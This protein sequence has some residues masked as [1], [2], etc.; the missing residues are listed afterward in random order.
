M[1]N[2]P[3]NEPSLSAGIN[4]TK[5][6][7]YW[8]QYLEQHVVNDA[9]LLFNDGVRRQYPEIF[10][11]KVERAVADKI[12]ALCKNNELSVYLYMLAA[13]GV[14][15]NKY[16]GAEYVTVGMPLVNEKDN[17]S[18]GTYNKWLPLFLSINSKRTFK[19]LLGVTS[20]IVSELVMHQ[21]YPLNIAYG[22]LNIQSAS[23]IFDTVFVCNNLHRVVPGTYENIPLV[24][25]LEIVE[26]EINFQLTTSVEPPFSVDVFFDHFHYV[27]TSAVNSLDKPLENIRISGNTRE[28][29]ALMKWSAGGDKLF[30]TSF[31]FRNE[32]S[33]CLT[34][35]GGDTAV[36]HGGGVLSYAALKHMADKLAG[37]LRIQQGIA[38]GQRVVV[39]Q[40]RS[41][42]TVVAALALLQYG[43]V[44]VPV[45]I[46]YPKERIRFMLKDIQPACVF[47]E[48]YLKDWVEEQGYK[49]F[50]LS[51]LLPSLDGNKAEKLPVVEIM[52]A[53]EAYIIYTSGSTGTPKGVRVS[54]ANLDH[55]FRHVYDHY[56][57]DE[58]LAMALLASH[59]FDISLFQLFTPLLSGGTCVVADKEE[60][61]DMDKLMSVLKNVTVIDTVPG[62]YRLLVQYI[63][64]RNL[65]SSFRHIRKLFI[66]GDHIPDNLLHELAE[67]FSEAAIIV[68]YGPT[69]GTIFCT[70]LMYE[71]GMIT[72][73][74]K[75]SIIGR[76]VDGSA[77]YILNK[78][79]SLLPAGVEGGIFIGGAGVSGGYL[80]RPELTGEKFVK[81]P[82][83]PEE[84]LYCTGDMGRWTAQ[85]HLE[86]R[87]RSD[88]QVKVRGYRIELGEIESCIRE[89]EEVADAVVTAISAKDNEKSLVA[90][91]VKKQAV[92]IWPSISEYLGYNDVAYFAMNHDKLRADSYKKAIYLAVKD[93]VVVDVGTGPEAILARH[94][95]EAGAKKVYAIELLEE[96]Y[97]KA[98]H[99]IESLGLQEKIILIH[100]NVLEVELPEPVDYCVCAL[101][102]NMGSSDGCIPVM[103]SA[104]RFL[105]DSRNM[106][107]Y[108][109][110]SKIA[111]VSL[112]ER[113]LSYRFTE[114][115]AYYVNS[116][117]EA[118]GEKFDLRVGLQHASSHHMISTEGIF[119]DLD[120]T[121]Y[122]PLDGEERIELHVILDAEMHG[123]LIWLNLYTAPGILNDILK[124]QQSFLPIYFPVF[125]QGLSV[126]K[127]DVIRAGVWRK[128]PAGSIYPDYGI[129]G[130]VLR[131]GGETYSFSYVSAKQP[132]AFGSTL[133]YQRLFPE[134]ELQVKPA[135]SSQVLHDFVGS[136][137]PSYMV[138]SNFVQ[139]EK[140]PLTPNGKL[141]KQALPPP[142]MAGLTT[143]YVAPRNE[144]ETVLAN[145]WQRLLRID[146]V[147]IHDD[148]FELGGHSLLGMRVVSAIRNELKVELGIKDLFALTTV[149]Q[150]AMHLQGK[151]KGILLSGI[152]AQKRPERTP[153]S[154]GQ[155]RLWFIDKLTGSVQYHLPMVLSLKG[156]LNEAALECAFQTVI[157]RHEVL[158]TII[159]QEEEQV[160]QQVL[161]NDSW[162]LD[163]IDS[164]EY[165]SD[166][167]NLATVMSDL[168]QQPFDLNKDYMLRAS[169]I[170]SGSGE[171]ILVMV[172]HHIAS[173]GWSMSILVRELM[174][175][176]ESYKAGGTADLPSLPLQY[177]DYAIWQRRHLQDKVL[178][179]QL[180]YWSGQLSGVMPLQL[181]LDHPRP[182]VQS[183]RGGMM[184]FEIG[185]ELS[186]QLKYIGQQQG[187]TLF[188]M[189]L[190][191]FKVLLYR[192]SGQ[193]D[194]CIGTPVA[195]RPQYELE[196]IIGFFVN[197]VALRSHVDGNVPFILFL[198]QIKAAT[199][200]AYEHQ[201]APFEKVVDAVVKKRDMGMAP[202]FQ[203][204]FALQNT[205]E[206]PEFKSADTRLS[207][208]PFGHTTSKFDL[209]FGI[210]EASTGE[211]LVDI[212][213]CTDL[214]DVARIERMQKHYQVLLESIVQMPGQKIDL[215]PIL[216]TS[217]DQGLRF[218]FNVAAAVN[219]PKEKTILDLF[220]SQVNRRRESVAIV[221]EDQAITYGALN[222]QANQLGH[223]LQSKGVGPEV[224]VP[225]CIERGIDMITGILG[226]LKAGGCYVPIDPDYPEERIAYMLEDTKAGLVLCN[227]KSRV[228]L[229]QMEGR[230]IIELDGDKDMIA[231]HSIAAV[232]NNLSAEHAAYVIYTSGSTGRPKGVVVE[233]RN[234]VRLFE[235]E[236]PL[237]DFNSEDVWTL[238]HSMCFDFSVW[239]MY[240]ALFYGGR[241]V[242]VPKVIT[243]D[244]RLFGELLM[245]EGVTVLNQTP[246]AF[247][248]L[249][250][251]AV[252]NHL[253]LAVRYIIF[254]GEA[255]NP[256]RLRDW[257]EYYKHCRL[258]NMYGITE[259]TVHVTFQE[260][261]DA[262]IL[263][264]RS[265]IGKPIPTL[266]AYLLDKA[267]N[268]VPVGVTGELHIGG[269]GVARGYLHQA[270]LT[271]ER[272]I[273]DKISGEP[274]GRLYR[275]G[276][277]ARW[278]ADGSLE[279]LGRLDNQVKIR[280]YR[281]ELGEVEEAMYESGLVSEGVVVAA[282]PGDDGI[283][284][285]VGYVVPG[286]SYSREGLQAFMRRRLP[287][288][289]VPPLVAE[290]EKIPLTANGKVDREL[291]PKPDVIQASQSSYATP[292]TSEEKE[293]AAIW[294]DLLGIEAIGVN[295]NFFELGGHS[296]LA[297]RVLAAVRKRLG[298]E[299]AVRDIFT[300][301]RLGELAAYIAQYGKEQ[302]LPRLSI[303]ERGDRIPLSFSQERLWFIDRLQGSVHYHIPMVLRLKGSLDTAALEYAFTAIMDRHEVLRTV[304]TEQEGRVYQ[305]I[306]PSGNQVFAH[307][308]AVDFEDDYQLQQWL[309]E[310][311]VRPFDLSRDYMLR[312]GLMHC[313]SHEHLLVVVLHHIASDGWSNSILMRELSAFYTAALSGQPPALEPLAVQYADYAIWQRR[314]LTGPVLEQQLLWWEERLKGVC[315]LQLPTDYP[316]PAV[317]SIRGADFTLTLDSQVLEGVEQLCRKTEVTLFM[318]LLSVFKVLLHR[319][320]GQRDICVG[321]P[322]AGRHHK[323]VEG[324]IGFFLNTL[325]LR[326]EVDSEMRFCDFLS[327]E[328]NMLLEAYS[329]QEA[330]FEQVV[331]RVAAERDM[332]RSSIFQVMFVLQ[333]TPDM[334]DV[335]LAPLTVTQELYGSIHTKYDL[336]FTIFETPD[337]YKLH[338]SYC[339][340]LYLPQTIERM[341][342]HYATLLSAAVSDPTTTLGHLRML[343]G[344]EEH[345]L[346]KEFN[347]TEAD[348]PV[349]ETVVSAF[350][351]H[352][353]NNPN[354]AAVVYKETCLT[355]SAL[356]EKANK[357]GKYLKAHYQV[358]PGDLVGLML[359]RSEWVIIGIM[360][361]LKAGAAYVPIDKK[362]P[363]QRKKYIL[364]DA[365]PKLLFTDVPLEPVLQPE[366]KVPW[367]LLS[368][369]LFADMEEPGD[370]LEHNKPE[371]PLYVI[372]TS[373]STGN[374]KGVLI[375]HA[376]ILN[377]MRGMHQV[378]DPDT[379]NSYATVTDISTDAGN[380]AIYGA[381]CF[382][383]TLD[384]IPLSAIETA[385]SFFDYCNSRSIDAIKFTPSFLAALLEG[386]ESFD[387]T[388]NQLLIGGEALS[389]SLAEKIVSRFRGK[390][391]YNHYGPTE[392]TI[393]VLVNNLS[394]CFNEAAA[395]PIG[396][397]LANTYAYILDSH[398]ELVPVGVVGE[399]YIGGKALARGYLNRPELTAA[400]FI[401]NPF[402][403]GER[404][405]RTGDLARWLPDGK[406]EYLGRTDDQVK[407][408]G[409]RIELGEIEGALTS[410]PLVRQ[411]VVLLRGDSN[412]SQRLVAYVVAA[413]VFDKEGMIRFLKE[414]LP[415]YMIPSL[416]VELHAMPL[417][418]NN[419]I[420]KQ[421]LPEPQISED[422]GYLAPRNE[423][424]DTLAKIWQELLELKQVG[425]NDNFFEMGGHSLLAIRMATAIKREFGIEVPVSVLFQY[426][427][428]MALGGYLQEVHGCGNIENLKRLQE[429]TVFIKEP[430]TPAEP[431]EYGGEYYYDI[432]AIQDYWVDEDKDR[433]YKEKDDSHGVI[434]KV[435]KVKKG[436]KP[437]TFMKAVSSIVSHHEALR[438]TFHRIDGKNMMKVEPAG[439]GKFETEYKDLRAAVLTDWAAVKYIIDFKD[440]KFSLTEGPLFLTRVVQ[441]GDEEYYISLKLH[442]VIS[443]TWSHEVLVSD[444]LVAYKNLSKDDRPGLTPLQYQYKEWLAFLNAYNDSNYYAHK[445]FWNSQ[446]PQLPG[447]LII[448]GAKK[449][450]AGKM[451]ERILQRMIITYADDILG[452]LVQLT[453]KFGTTLFVVLQTTVKTFLYSKTGQPDISFGTYVSGRDYPGSQYLLGC[454][455]ATA[456]I[457]T[458]FSE[459]DSFA[460]AVEKVKQ[461]NYEMANYKAY[462]LLDAILE[463]T[464]PSRDFDAFWKINMLYSD[465]NGFSA[466][467]AEFRHLIEEAGIDFTPVIDNTTALIPI[468]WILDF[469]YSKDKLVIDFQ[470]DSSLYEA[471]VVQQ[472]MDEYF[473]YVKEVMADVNLPLKRY[474]LLDKLD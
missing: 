285:L 299:V 352:A 321:T 298:V 238:F 165:G 293:I 100:G 15:I 295:D 431:K 119:E 148:F 269:A 292:L 390:G 58:K 155:E 277:M 215:L 70:H 258:I 130:E 397:P 115:G 357:L 52:P 77:I 244:A 202:L 433:E 351:W 108:R 460:A 211:L 270:R 40:S 393:G 99:K 10:R 391:I 17:A 324:L 303:Q 382:G 3:L 355:Y 189:L 275:T 159:V 346:L 442:H 301:T 16:T 239:E 474:A 405:Y 182:V 453:K 157:Q 79:L 278:R 250:D 280:G 117:F 142:D 254:G 364:A 251:Y 167:G 203:V 228:V 356:N 162:Q 50:V 116:I 6:K 243:R 19:E 2:A 61:Q 188:M 224:L 369:D 141:N 333:N 104:R 403:A 437:D 423:V 318:V 424:E 415:E 25:T 267:G 87:G 69:E 262:H 409:Y 13:Y 109:S 310:E 379:V 319:Y 289:M 384:I 39:L 207:A 55:F 326:S 456:L 149:S 314:Y 225:I 281:I 360:A 339:S 118:T 106:I 41:E 335:D 226:I 304:F 388:F 150:L 395:P 449:Q 361:I 65:S 121:A 412:S 465:T 242:V 332:S 63:N 173:D 129:A 8:L 186:Q 341:A 358:G 366:I 420:D 143:S 107:P 466:N 172:L 383:K 28:T 469:V 73:L 102:G 399:L 83:E 34:A 288:Y 105:K 302:L 331:G 308:T 421:A 268:L 191:A 282:W 127:G 428:I 320:S 26:N 196:K 24:V 348:F 387:W 94:C 195:N 132:L 218:E 201:E 315:P 386:D 398:L 49:A 112:P 463:L 91:Y 436:F 154:F 229:P 5:S 439:S 312:V 97:L 329:H 406:V 349:N 350:E 66:G 265:M 20:R 232:T 410:S 389:R 457:R 144:T 164:K 223:Y 86:F 274:E 183:F 54:H 344:A 46:D 158:R 221:F 462:T 472:I 237:Y 193:E 448:P 253:P 194:I 353:A 236:S 12:L 145:I 32:L 370:L 404:L 284:Q 176:Y 230:E 51:S 426:P 78:E 375:E 198:Q 264:G 72:G 376:A 57:D 248:V 93:K 161:A 76:P 257:K 340:D 362:F 166:D 37:Y 33:R 29:A 235:T 96:V 347:G 133:F 206:L 140:L 256:S 306:L 71:P 311:L 213:Y 322:V 139:L 131:P 43:W 287:E 44:Y 272:F 36:V 219:Y 60:L 294:S 381:L 134:G 396:R 122:L 210:R 9:V 174:E 440:H 330:P 372:Y 192:Y 68:T 385:T 128:T 178:E 263:E 451:E 169:L 184:N 316:R 175:A 422:Q 276:D 81:S 95:L 14:T 309:K 473:L 137:L 286:E 368:E 31:S 209:S 185:A 98:K 447:E 111:A 163:L 64:E 187:A 136:R 345:Q 45:D 425:I 464:A 252:E 313:A 325:A 42:N 110:I 291:L 307:S 401:P 380:T 392:T 59:A 62:M 283:R 417:T 317:Q 394:E 204:V 467:G 227:S 113:A 80:N 260:L 153:L 135:L 125:E 180:A 216:T 233:H 88:D 435:Y 438:S 200:A 168:I 419:K 179:E 18:A 454:L 343:T 7:G 363:D 411:A 35:Y 74:T 443:D 259:T 156:N 279:Y 373:G 246:S 245:R 171:Y 92:Q 181:P 240:G 444:L 212:E 378:Y 222:E 374:P 234:V 432:T 414:R 67:L 75:G 305:A 208:V 367:Q 452:Q 170:R 146:Q 371:D 205:P 177:A 446:C 114:T 261:S 273:A 217:E 377:Y 450:Y 220:E 338:I 30:H 241:L 429:D 455:A 342:G 247:Y 459:E 151:Q 197:M 327:T 402:R 48:G 138:P 354:V 53:D 365:N 416:W 11:Y 323:E 359:D 56:I 408:R 90:Y 199:L 89:H 38:K 470:Y 427:D 290:I 468:H 400:K 441:T 21:H 124:S 461:A 126:R 334:P 407:V 249:Q 1:A 418:K 336:T 84:I 47:T 413:G 337:G 430:G 190:A 123:F 101:V 152:A 271:S 231:G 4:I 160:W 471:A 445:A 297:M 328:R 300:Y 23:A 85:G 458:V 120:L 22:E 103:N 266:R 82:F 434:V 255:L 147:G 27:I 296:L 214:F